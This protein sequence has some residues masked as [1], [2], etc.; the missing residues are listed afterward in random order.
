[1]RCAGRPLPLRPALVSASETA[2]VP[3][4]ARSAPSSP[5]EVEIVG[6]LIAAADR[7]D[8]GADLIGERMG[9]AYGIAA[10]REAARQQ[11]G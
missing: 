5:L 4:G 11:L 8:T 2:P 9:D 10:I 7:E 6:V 1:M 3:R